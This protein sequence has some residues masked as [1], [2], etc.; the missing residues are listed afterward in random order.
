MFFNR[1]F[2]SIR[3]ICKMDAMTYLGQ[4][5]SD[6]KM[7]L[8]CL[9]DIILPRNCVVCGRTLL[10]HEKHI[11]I[12]CQSEIPLTRY[13]MNVQNPMADKF[14][15]KI[16]ER[17]IAEDY[18]E[19]YEPYAFA[20]SLFFYNEHSPYAH[21]TRA[22]KY[23]GNIAEGRYFAKML[24][25]K[26]KQTESF[27][28]VDAVVPVPLHWT[29]KWKR[30]YNQAEIIAR[31]VAK[32]LEAEVRTDILKRQRRTQTQTKLSVEAKGSNVKGAFAAKF[33]K[34]SAIPKHILLI[35]D[36]FTTGS[37]LAACHDAIRNALSELGISPTQCRISVATLAC[38]GE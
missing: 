23:H 31:E 13:W 27:A 24:G 21:I 4:V 35:D 28:T 3:F 2:E 17:I 14:N 29:R 11:C 15:A 34:G 19:G 18:D 25:N 7:S 36:V 6:A 12:Y 32:A 9:L 30:G 37:T 16:Q 20:T 33:G 1:K 8:R 26:I 38:V 10:R 22:L 5:Y